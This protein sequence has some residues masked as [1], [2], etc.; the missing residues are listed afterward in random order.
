MIGNILANGGFEINGCTNTNRK[1]LWNSQ[2]FLANF[3]PGWTPIPEIKIVKSTLLNP[4]IGNSWVA[5]LDAS[6][7]TCIVQNIN[8]RQGR[9]FLKFN[10]AA[11]VNTPL[12]SNGILVIL[13]RQLLKSIA[14]ADY[15]LHTENLEFYVNSNVAT[16]ELAICGAGRSDGVGALIDSI[17]LKFEDESLFRINKY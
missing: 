9:H 13:N 14:S 6:A 11:R 16:V 5:E 7:N 12:P 10:R 17:D 8:L 1:C 15:G 2:N 3:V 4:A